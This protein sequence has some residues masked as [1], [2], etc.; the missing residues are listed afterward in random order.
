MNKL[1]K[2]NNTL[3]MRTILYSISKILSQGI[4]AIAAVVFVRLLT[5]EEYGYVSIY[6]A[7]VSI[8]SV[9]ISLRTDGTIQMARTKYGLEK[10]DEYC[11]CALTISNLFF[12]WYFLLYWG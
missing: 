3:T 7:W 8:V 11:S 9:F 10:T 2:R 1:L 6:T 4:N 12:L 5:T